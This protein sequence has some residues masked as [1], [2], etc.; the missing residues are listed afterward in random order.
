MAEEK[1]NVGYVGPEMPEHAARPYCLYTGPTPGVPQ[2][3]KNATT[4]LF[5]S[6]PTMGD[7][8]LATCPDHEAIAR[9]AGDV[10][11]EHGFGGF[12]GMPGT[13][14]SFDEHRCIIDD[15]GVEL[16]AKAAEMVGVS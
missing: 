3:G 12:C 15:S 14:W 13:L 11:D 2:C 5:V 7:V 8:A 16:P 4:H 9:A 1:P 10:V 6:S